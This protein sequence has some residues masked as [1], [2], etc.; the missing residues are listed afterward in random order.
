[1][2][3]TLLAIAAVST[4]AVAAASAQD[5]HRPAAARVTTVLSA[6]ANSAGQPIVFPVRNGHVTASIYEIPPGATLP[7]HKHPFPRM[8]YVL[9]GSLRVTDVEAGRS[10]D[11][12]R[13][14]FMLESV[15]RW[16]EGSNVGRTPLRLLVID[17]TEKGAAATLLKR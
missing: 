12:G 5:E 3:N 10:R 6:D 16:H 8:A 7:V 13:G 17:L 15:D 2:K 4:A 11:Y 14:D 1:M 9:E